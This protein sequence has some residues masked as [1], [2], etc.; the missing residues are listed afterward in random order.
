MVLSVN[1]MFYVI[2]GFVM[3][4]D[5]TSSEVFHD[6]LADD[7]LQERITSCRQALHGLNA[8][9]AVFV[10]SMSELSTASPRDQISGELRDQL[11]DEAALMIPKLSHKVNEVVAKIMPAHKNRNSDRMF[12]N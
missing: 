5:K 9:A 8:A 10:Q 2:S 7:S 11:F 1:I 6:T 3:S 4:Q 12:S